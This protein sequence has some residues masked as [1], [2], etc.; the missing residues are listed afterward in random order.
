META[1]QIINLSRTRACKLVIGS[2]KT[3]LAN[4]PNKDLLQLLAFS[5]RSFYFLMDA[6]E[7]KKV[8]YRP[9][10]EALEDL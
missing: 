8:F 10:N 4:R 9:R 6:R 3:L 1:C 2:P 7:T 5:S